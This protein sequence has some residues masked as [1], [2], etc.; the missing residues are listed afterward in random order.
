M[1]PHGFHNRIGMVAFALVL[2]LLLASLTTGDDND[3]IEIDI[4]LPVI[5]VEFNEDGQQGVVEAGQATGLVVGGLRPVY[6]SDQDEGYAMIGDAELS[7]IGDTLTVVTFLPAD[8]DTLEISDLVKMRLERPRPEGDPLIWRLA[9]LGVALLD[10][11]SEVI[12]TQSDILGDVDGPTDEQ[13]LSRCAELVRDLAARL[14]IEEYPGVFDPIEGGRYAGRTTIDVM[15][16]ATP[17]DI[18]SMCYYLVSYPHMYIGYRWCIENIFANWVSNGGSDSSLEILYAV[19]EM[20]HDEALAHIEA[21]RQFAIDLVI[22]DEWYTEMTRCNEEGRQDAREAIITVMGWLAEAIDL[23]RFQELYWSAKANFDQDREDWDSAVEGWLSAAEASEDGSR[24]EAIYFNNRANALFSAA[25]Y[26]EALAS[27]ELS[28]DYYGARQDTLIDADAAEAWRGVADSLAE[29]GRVDE[30]GAAMEASAELF[31]QRGGLDDLQRRARALSKLGDIY[32]AVGRNR[33][34]I[35]AWQR[36]LETAEE[37]AWEA[38]VASALDDMS[39]GYWN[40]GELDKAVETRLIAVDIYTALGNDYSLAVANTNLGSLYWE[41]GRSDEARQRYEAAMAVHRAREEWWDVAD[42]LERLGANE[43]IKGN[44]ETALPLLAEAL[45]HYEGGDWPKDVGEVLLEMAECH[46]GLGRTAPA[47]SAYVRALD[48]HRLANN[49]GGEARVLEWWGYS[50]FTRKQISAAKEKLDTAKTLSE[51]AGNL[52]SQAD[53]WRTLSL[54]HSALDGEHQAAIDAARSSLAIARSMPSK[55]KEAEA[56]SMIASALLN[57]GQIDEAFDSMREAM[58]LFTETGDQSGLVDAHNTLGALHASRGRYD[59]AMAAYREAMATAEAADLEAGVA[60]ALTS[61]AWQLHHNGDNDEAIVAAERAQAIYEGQSNSW[62]AA[63]LYNTVGAARGSQGLYDEAILQ[64]SL[65]LAIREEWGDPYGMA[66]AHNNMGDIYKQLGDYETAIE[67]FET[68]LEIGERIRFVDVQTITAGN[69]AQC[70]HELGRTD[71]ALVLIKRGL[72]LAREEDAPPRIVDML[73]FLGALLYEI[74]ELDEAAEALTDGL[75]AA[76][77]MG[78]TS[79]THSLNAKLGAL[80]WKR[81]RYADAESRLGT[82]VPQLREMRNPTM[83]WEP[84][85]YL[86][87]VQR[88]QGATETA[89]SSFRES[90]AALEEVRTGLKDKNVASGFQ[91]KN[92]DVYRELVSLLMELGREEEAFE[93]LGL[94]KTQETREMG[95]GDGPRL[96]DDDQ[97]LVTEA[98][99]LRSREARLVRQLRDELTRAADLQRPELITVWQAEIDSLKLHFHD[100]TRSLRD[101]HP[102]AFERLEVAPVSF[103]QLRR[104]LL[105]TEAFVEPVI[106]PD[107]IVVFV[108]RGGDD[109][110]VYREIPAKEG[111]VHELIRRMREGLEHPDGDW[112]TERTARLAGRPVPEQNIDPSVPARELYGLLIEPLAGDLVGVETLIVSPSGRLRYIPFGALYDGERYLLERFEVSVLTQAGTL[113]SRRS[114]PTDAALLAFG[115]PDSTLAGAEA[116][117][118]DLEKIWAPAHVTAVY[119]EHATKERLRSEAGSHNILHLAT[120]GVLLNE[121]P[122]ASYL[123][124]AGTDESAHLTFRDIV[125]LDLYDVDL[126]VLSACETAVGDHGEGKEIAGLAYNFEQTGAAAVIASLWRVNDTSTSGLMTRLY[127]NLRQGETT[128]SAALREAQLTLRH[129][130]DYAHPYYWAPFILI[131]NWR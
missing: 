82:L 7:R 52:G 131:G 96:S 46:E 44:F 125:L 103:N 89:V 95:V 110:L 33:E 113:T 81:E 112:E 64:Y 22:M 90:I 72:K 41:L 94:M 51:A 66:G 100:F 127:R 20:E 6:R 31:A 101:E 34:A 59:E 2:P 88:D 8:D 40:L 102:Q 87:R 30:A 45:A 18:R 35:D 130:E 93:I 62:A 1:R 86:G 84:L 104:G 43:R 47:D 121:H 54:I 21:R 57:M 13:I 73:Y 42:V 23:P 77:G 111:R 71:E 105:E 124:L 26:E 122:E 11:S 12:F 120:H 39:D 36:G 119:G 37:L 107:R 56:L 80:D 65:S 108:V 29:L 126:T 85:F 55:Q 38:T 78:A 97:A 16:R 15:T 48:A 116:E 128:K 19:L 49:A 75:E 25:R 61:I 117:V 63:N 3:T 115:N 28:L 67:H 106:L 68:A 91:E 114:V 69:L 60:N 24:S 32:D 118:S 27:Y 50:L 9:C 70:L 74:D 109:P 14:T 99:A 58:T 129:S 10:V 83:I 5:Q 4:F 98:E 79:T 17:D 53:I 76:A 92:S 123:V